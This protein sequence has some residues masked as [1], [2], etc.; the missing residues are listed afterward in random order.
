MHMT[1]IRAEL[2]RALRTMRTGSLCGCNSTER[3]PGRA[4]TGLQMQAQD[5]VDLWIAMETKKKSTH[6]KGAG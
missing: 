3:K 2:A 4:G 5:G 6:K 1:A